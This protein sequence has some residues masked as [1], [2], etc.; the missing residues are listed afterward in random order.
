RLQTLAKPLLEDKPLTRKVL[1]RVL[2]LM[3]QVPGVKVQPQMELPKYAGGGT[4][5]VLH[6]ERRAFRAEGGVVDMGAGS[7]PVVGISAGSLT[8]LGEQIRLTGAVPIGSRDVKYIAGTAVVPIGDDGLEWVIDGYH[9]GA[10]PRDG[11]L[12]DL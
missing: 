12:E 9:Y 5:L 10:R 7:Q 8:P 4:P 6:V 3:R 11:A 2:N 1:E